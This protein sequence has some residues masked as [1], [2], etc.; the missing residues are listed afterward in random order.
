MGD[1]VVASEPVKHTHDYQD[2]DPFSLRAY[3]LAEIFGEK[4]RTIYQRSRGRDYYDLYQIIVGDDTP[5]AEPVASIFD[6]K[7]VHA[8]VGSYHTPPNP[9]DG[10][11]D[12]AAETIAD[13]WQTTLPALVADVPPL[14]TVQQR[15]DV[16]LT[17]TL[18][19]VLDE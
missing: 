4:L 14:E 17:E 2:L 16:Y 11:P 8:P 13:D 1:E 7:R 18:A 12:N 3:S 15:L 5:S 6:E 9:R 10:V 19:P